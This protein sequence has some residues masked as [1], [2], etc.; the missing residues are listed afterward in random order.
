MLPLELPQVDLDA[1][2]QDASAGL[3]LAVDLENEV[4]VRPNGKPPVPFKIDA[5]RRHCLINGLDD[6]GLTLEH[7]EDIEKFEE[8]RSQVWPWLDGVGY[9]KKG[10]KV[11][12]V[13]V[14]GAKKMTEW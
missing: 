11:V 9:A 13:P 7:R 3:E 1:L 8:K 14:G 2:Y 12:A 4:V 6:I 5:F 10:Q